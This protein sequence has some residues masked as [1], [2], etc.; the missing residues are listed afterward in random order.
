[1]GGIKRKESPAANGA[2]NKKQKL[3]SS[4]PG[5]NAKPVQAA[6]VPE[7]EDELEDEDDDEADDFDGLSD[8]SGGAA[9]D[10][11]L[12]ESDDETQNPSKPT[13]R[14]GED[15][16][17]N[18][19]KTFKLESTSAE[20]HAKQRALAKERK[21]SKPNADTI[22]QSK[23]IWERLRMKNNVPAAERKQLVNELF[24]L[25]SGKVRDFVFKHDSVRV[26]QCT[27]K[28]ANQEQ[29][30]SIAQE[31]QGDI[32]TLAES[33]Y[34]KF[35]VAKMVVEGT[36]ETRDMIVPEFYGHVRRLINHPEASWIV[37]DIYRQ[38]ATPQQKAT[39]LRE[40]YGAEF[41]LFHKKPSAS[42]SKTVAADNTADLKAILEANPEK[43]KVILQYLLQ[44][45]NALVQ[46]KMTGFTML[47]DA[48]LQYFLALQPGSEEHREFM[49][50]LKG[51]IDPD[52]EGGGGDLFKNL[53][54]TK[55]GSRLVSLAIAYGTAKD[56]KVILRVFKGTVEM[57]SMDQ[58]AKTVLCV[59]LD[60]PD[61]VTMSSKAV[62]GE[63]LNVRIDDESKR[64]DKVQET[65]LHPNA[66]L[67]V[68]YPM[69][70]MAKW[71]VG[72][73]EKA[74]L[75][76]VQEIRKTTS[77]KAPELRRAG[78]LE[79]L[80]G[81]V[82]ELVSKRAEQ[83]AQTTF[84][85]QFITET[86]LAANGEQKGEAKRAVASLAQGDPLEEEHLAKNPAAGR[87]LR[88]L[89]S[90]GTFDPTTKTTVLAEPNLTFADVLYPVI[91]NH[92][93]QWACSDSSFVVVALLETQDASAAIKG[94]VEAKLKKNKKA[95]EAA[96]NGS[97]NAK[98]KKGENSDVADA[99]K[100][101]K[102]KSSKGNAGARILLEKL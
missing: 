62:F 74:L 26:V 88:T 73:A 28:F 99:K 78:L 33:K 44:M 32:R 23:K 61:D 24:E 92:I 72:D 2:G 55:S 53:A 84:G 59:A 27:L 42:N 95:L 38:V 46:K 8:S 4:K 57:M 68:L 100:N 47:H 14:S 1:M 7:S 54:F 31:L 20:A 81:P 18:D 87:M 50:I 45:I 56:R 52:V 6:P 97:G 22:Q 25:I 83:L 29:R 102:Q 98:S 75:M 37:D 65:L 30:K 69:A 86:L 16:D 76:E 11:D 67:P 34:G 5:K 93:V 94:E 49:E 66:R 64:L 80:S 85:C 41:A 12:E 9:L 79:H 15:V 39:M 60:V 21:A 35:M 51:D 91:K 58:H 101:K 40:W 89:V 36:D 63:L 19:P 17:G 96:A 43:R 3:A 10:D 77:K 90:G 48:M 71:L 82:L 70:G 13:K